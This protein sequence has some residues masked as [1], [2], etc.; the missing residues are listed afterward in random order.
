KGWVKLGGLESVRDLLRD[1][2]FIRFIAAGTA[3]YA[4][5]V[6]SLLLQKLTPI[7]SQSEVA[8]EFNYSE[9]NWPKNSVAWFISQSGETA[10]ILKSIE[11][12]RADR[13]TPLGL[14]NVVGSS[15]AQRTTAGV[16]LHA[17]PEIAVASTKA[18]TSQIAAL[19]MISCW[20]KQNR[21]KGRGGS[22]EALSLAMNL[23][24]LPA[25]VAK[26]LKL[27]PEIKEL[28]KSLSGASQVLFFGRGVC[29]PLALEAALKLREVAYM[30]TIG[31]PI[32][33]LKHGPISAMD[34]DRPAV[35]FAPSDQT[36][37]KNRSNIQELKARNIPTYVITDKFGAKKLSDVS[38]EILEVPV[39]HELLAPVTM[40]V[41]VQLLA[42]EIGILLGRPIDKPRNLAKSVTV[43]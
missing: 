4:G 31:L 13:I 22:G 2:E 23:P 16:Y 42:Y 17:G 25:A 24:E 39:V 32:G 38:E 33:E 27:R 26:T 29:Y 9:L 5:M 15:I 28:A 36:L 30:N 43:E 37:E 10:D 6:G 3:G 14:V 18:F 7:V 41:V 19:A 1:T 11:K 21:V 8:S 40:A 34:K 12:V 35:I 20:L